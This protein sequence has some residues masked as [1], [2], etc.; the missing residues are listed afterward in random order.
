MSIPPW[1][2]KQP[3]SSC[4]AV[5]SN[6]DFLQ[7]WAESMLSRGLK[8]QGFVHTSRFQQPISWSK[9]CQQLQQIDLFQEKKQWI[10]TPSRGED[11]KS[12]DF[13]RFIDL[14]LQ[15]SL[16]AII[17]LLPVSSAGLQKHKHHQAL[18]KHYTH[19]TIK[20]LYD[21]EVPAWL[22]SCCQYLKISLTPQQQRELCQHTQNQPMRLWQSLLMM[23]SQ[24][25]PIDNIHAFIKSSPLEDSVFQLTHALFTGHVPSCYRLMAQNTHAEFLQKTFWIS[26][27]QLR[28]IVLHKET[29]TQQNLSINA[30]LSRIKLWSTLKQQYQACLQVPLP[31]LQQHY[32]DL[33]QCEW[34]LKG[35]LTE[36]FAAT[37]RRRL[38]QLC[39]SI[40]QARRSS[41]D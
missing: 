13:K 18:K 2:F 36:D 27:K 21:N 15:Q 26:L 31:Q 41:H 8:N 33:C 34:A 14:S 1:L 17:L 16:Y 9:L 30:Y 40:Q 10:I 25:Q 4:I 11:I 24:S 29:L 6:D 7:H 12:D 37:L 23:S 22:K 3:P 28:T 5:E 32:Y 35:Y 38:Q 39:L 19:V 20:T